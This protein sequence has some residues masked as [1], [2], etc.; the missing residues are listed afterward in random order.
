MRRD[1]VKGL[2]STIKIYETLKVALILPWRPASNE[3]NTQTATKPMSATDNSYRGRFESTLNTYFK[4][5]VRE[6]GSLKISPILLHLYV[7]TMNMIYQWQTFQNK[8]GS[9]RGLLIKNIL[10]YPSNWQR[11]RSTL[12][13]YR[14]TR[15]LAY[16]KLI[17]SL[18]RT[19]TSRNFTN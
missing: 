16:W 19:T 13:E 6:R 3:N 11:I 10:V 14:I 9:E 2:V 7:A 15:C 18:E 4:L 1:I 12:I 17:N 5:A 8:F